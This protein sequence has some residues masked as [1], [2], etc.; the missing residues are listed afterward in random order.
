MTQV[1]IIRDVWNPLGFH[2]NQK[3][4]KS[5]K[6]RLSYGQQANPLF[7]LGLD[8]HLRSSP[9]PFLAAYMAYSS[10]ATSIFVKGTIFCEIAL[11]RL[12]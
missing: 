5:G 1:S 2:L 12:I 9:R 4:L 3:D 8:M 10:S 7:N 11:K 6:K